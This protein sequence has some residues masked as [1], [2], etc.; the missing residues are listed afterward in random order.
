MSVETKLRR[1]KLNLRRKRVPPPLPTG[2]GEATGG[3]RRGTEREAA[4]AI[5]VA[6]IM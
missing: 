4:A 6:Y 3:K 2:A 1:K 5:R